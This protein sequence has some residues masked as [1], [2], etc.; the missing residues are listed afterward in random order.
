MTSPPSWTPTAPEGPVVLVGHSMGGMT[1][2]SLAGQHPDVVRERVV[3]VALIA[4]SAGG[5][6]R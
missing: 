6:R 4:T 2:M 5:A 3:A 1:V